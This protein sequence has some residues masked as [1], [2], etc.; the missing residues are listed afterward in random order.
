MNY[1]FEE[2]MML[3]IAVTVS[4]FVVLGLTAHIIN[5]SVDQE[6]RIILDDGS[7]RE[8]FGDI[9]VWSNG[10]CRYRDAEGLVHTVFNIKEI[11]RIR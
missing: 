3:F 2:K 11:I 5:E 9:T 8:A 7:E 4:V 6:H 1:D 10:K